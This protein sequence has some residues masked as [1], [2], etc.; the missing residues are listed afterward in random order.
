MKQKEFI[1]TVNGG[2]TI[3]NVF[4]WYQEAWRVTLIEI[5]NNFCVVSVTEIL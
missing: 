3:L 5:S 2:N 1:M 4:V